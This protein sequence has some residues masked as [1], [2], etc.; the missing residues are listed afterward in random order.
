M[1]CII[2]LLDNA[3]LSKKKK[4]EST[5]QIIISKGKN[6]KFS[7]ENFKNGTWTGF[8]TNIK[9]DNETKNRK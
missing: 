6:Q 1:T 9:N 8:M 3:G 5:K 4:K 2:C 7:I